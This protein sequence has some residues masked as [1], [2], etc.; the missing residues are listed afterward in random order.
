MK[1][2]NFKKKLDFKKIQ[3]ANMNTIRGGDLDETQ[4]DQTVC[5]SFKSLNGDISCPPGNH[6][7]TR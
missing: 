3:I 7:C 5:T 1:K 4:D 2:Q 6:A